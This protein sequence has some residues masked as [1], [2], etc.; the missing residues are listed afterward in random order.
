MLKTAPLFYGKEKCGLNILQS[1]VNCKNTI[2]HSQ[3]MI[4]VEIA[5]KIRNKKCVKT[6]MNLI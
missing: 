2:S 5:Q 4:I 3:K 1:S 6:R